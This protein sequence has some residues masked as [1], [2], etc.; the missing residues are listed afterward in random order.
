MLFISAGRFISMFYG[1]G[2]IN[3]HF[4]IVTVMFLSFWNLKG[5]YLSTFFLGTKGQVEEEE[6]EEDE[7]EEEEEEDNKEQQQEQVENEKNPE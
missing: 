6:E 7:E 2:V 1:A 3:V 4:F 5:V